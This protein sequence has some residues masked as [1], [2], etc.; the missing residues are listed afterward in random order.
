MTELRLL[1]TR[2]APVGYATSTDYNLLV[3]GG[4]AKALT[5]GQLITLRGF[6]LAVVSPNGCLNVDQAGIST[7]VNPAALIAE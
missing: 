6:G 1:R 7:D 5:A 4:V 2:R 3:Q